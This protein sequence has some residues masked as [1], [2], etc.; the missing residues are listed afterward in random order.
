MCRHEVVAHGQLY[1][2]QQALPGQ[3]SF[4]Y[5]YVGQAFLQVVHASLPHLFR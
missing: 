1:R 4:L 2:G 5:Q 3:P